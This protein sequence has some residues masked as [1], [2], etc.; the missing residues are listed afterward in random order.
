MRGS[1]VRSRHRGFGVI[2]SSPIV[3]RAQP[4]EERMSRLGRTLGGILTVLTLP[5]TGA[6]QLPPLPRHS[7][8]AP[9][10]SS[11]RCS[12]QQRAEASAPPCHAHR[13][14]PGDDDDRRAI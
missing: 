5:A 14:A 12:M 9:E 10:S 3:G 11:D 13:V 1:E 2:I 8:R 6:A 4:Q 7:R